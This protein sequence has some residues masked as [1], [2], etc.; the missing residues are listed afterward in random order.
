MPSHHPPPD[1]KYTKDFYNGTAWVTSNG[2]SGGALT[3]GSVVFAGTG[4]AL[5]QNN[6]NFFW[7]NT[8]ARLGIGTASPLTPLSVTYAGSDSSATTNTGISAFKWT[9]FGLNM[10]VSA[11]SGS[12]WIQG[13]NTASGAVGINLQPS[14]GNVGIGIASTATAGET[15]DIKATNNTGIRVTNAANTN[16]Q[17]ALRTMGSNGDLGIFTTAAASLTQQMTV[18][19]GGNLGIGDTTPSAMLTVGNGDLF[20]VNSS[21]AIAASTGVTSSGNVAANGQQSYTK[22]ALIVGANATTGDFVQFSDT[23]DG[24]T[25]NTTNWVTSGTVTQSGSISS[26]GAGWTTGMNST[27]TYRRSASLTLTAD[28]V[29]A[30]SSHMVVGFSSSTIGSGFNSISHGIYFEPDNLVYIAENSTNRGSTGY[31]YTPGATY[32]VKIVTNSTGALYYISSDSGDTWTKIYDGTANSITNSPLYVIF[33]TFSGTQ[34]IDNVSVSNNNDILV[35]SQLFSKNLTVGNGNFLVNSGN[36][37][38][39]VTTLLAGLHNARNGAASTPA[40]MLSGTWFT[41]GSGTTTKPQLLI[42]PTGT[43]STS[44]STSGT[45]FGINAASGFAGNLVDIKVNNTSKFSVNSTGSLTLGNALTLGSPAG[46]EF[47]SFIETTSNQSPASSGIQVWSGGT[48][49]MVLMSNGIRLLNSGQ[50][51]W[52]SVDAIDAEDTGIARST[53][54]NIKITNGGSTSYWKIGAAGLLATTDNSID[55]GA[56]GATRPRSIYAGTSITTA[57]LTA[58][59]TTSLADTTTSDPTP[60]L[61]D[62]GFVTCTALTTVANVITCTV[63]DQTVKKDFQPFNNGLAFIRNIQPQTYAFREGTPYYDNNRTRLGLIAQE[64]ASAGL[65]DAVLPIGNGLSQIDFNA[66]TAA[67]IS[68]VKDLDIAVQGLSSLDTSNS[69][70][71]GSL[72]KQF[73]GDVGN[74]IQNLFVKKIHTEELCVKKSD[75]NDVCITGDQLQQLLNG[76]APTSGGGSGGGSTTGGDSGDT[77]GSTGSDGSGGETGDSGNTGGDGSTGDTGGDTGSAGGDT[78]GS[79]GAGDSG[80]SG[81]TGS[82][83]STPPAGDGAIQ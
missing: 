3:L 6:S 70:S 26:V 51:K 77:G 36:I 41:G 54:G 18:T 4:G 13:N 1:L 67:T 39:G 35:G 58:T 73:L 62:A 7:D 34:A 81:D 56:A 61:S 68:A 12:T 48:S 5:S 16:V 32:R 66:V 20:Q 79:S 31:T 10:G 76:N 14:G 50:F 46:G 49:A 44:W 45:A 29:P 42:Q 8:N 25:I 2:T 17:F 64:V 65:T 80:S 11:N 55:I 21:G 15:L 82:G 52:A 9:T 22:G 74:G 83:D 59:G 40:E 53:A 19:A 72:I 69:N 23:F 63:S 43:T 37:G 28:V 30:S 60:T 33:A 47:L 78:G 27:Q 57:A 24:S 71:L 38:I 75:G